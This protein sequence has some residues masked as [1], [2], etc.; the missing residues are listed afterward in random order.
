MEIKRIHRIKL[1][2]LLKRGKIMKKISMLMFVFLIV[3]VFG[4]ACQFL[5][6]KEVVADNKTAT[7]TASTNSG[8]VQNTDA[9]RETEQ[10]KGIVSIDDKPDFS[11]QAEELVKAQ[12]EAKNTVIPPEKFRDKIVEVS[13]R[14]SNLR[15][16]KE[17][18]LAP[19][20]QLKGGRPVLEDVWCDFDEENK[21]EI[22]NL[23]KDQMVTLKGLVPDMWLMNPSLKHCI[24]VEAK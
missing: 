11:V 21:A 1:I 10:K 6:A 2:D 23:K 24:I 7:N 19:G 3:T 20:V 18:S 14:V 12:K 9:K 15:P 4:T 22:T 13:G 5:K 8:K 17:K 16:E